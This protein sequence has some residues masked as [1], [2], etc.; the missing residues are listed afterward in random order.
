MGNEDGKMENSKEC[1][2]KREEFC[3]LRWQRNIRDRRAARADLHNLAQQLGRICNPAALSI[4]ICNAFFG[5]KILILD[6]SGLQIPMS[7]KS[8]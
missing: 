7:C 4:S 6:P 5:L 1:Q 3:L 2:R 8:I